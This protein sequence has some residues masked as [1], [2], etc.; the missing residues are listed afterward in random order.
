MPPNR[1]PANDPIL[2]PHRDDVG[3]LRSYLDAVL[4]PGPGMPSAVAID[5]EMLGSDRYVA[6]EIKN[7]SQERFLVEV[8]DRDLNRNA[9]MQVLRAE[10]GRSPRPRE[11][12]L[13]EAQTLAGLTHPALP[14]VFDIGFLPSGEIYYTHRPP[15]GRPAS[16]LATDESARI[17]QVE[18]LLGLATAA[19][20]IDQAGRAGLHHP[21]LSSEHVAMG[22]DGDVQ[23]WGFV[24]G[25]GPRGD[26]DAWPEVMG[27]GKV[28]YHLL[29]GLPPDEPLT[30]PRQ[31]APHRGI[32]VDLQ[33]LCLRC[34]G[35]A[36]PSFSRPQGFARAL[37][38]LLEG[39][40]RRDEAERLVL[41]A[42]KAMK[43]A[44]A[45]T[46][47]SLRLKGELGALA[48][49]PSLFHT[50]GA[51]SKR[52]SLDDALNASRAAAEASS[53]QA[54]DHL[55]RALERNP[56][57]LEALAGLSDLYFTR[58]REAE[59]ARDPRDMARWA[60]A[61][62]RVGPGR[63]D[64]R[65]LAP[66]SLTLTSPSPAATGFLSRME[67]KERRSLPGPAR[68]LG[69]LPIEEFSLAPGSYLVRVEAP[70]RA[71]VLV[72]L[73]IRRGE[74]L[75]LSIPLLDAGEVGQDWVYI[76]P[77]PCELGGD[78][79][80]PE[81]SPPLSV[82]VPPFLMARFPVTCGDFAAWIRDLAEKDPATADA[83]LPRP[84]EGGEPLWRL[85]PSGH[86][87]ATPGSS[88][89]FS[90]HP[91]TPVVG[92]TREQAR[93]YARWLS[94]R[95]GL[96]VRLPDSAEWEKAGR[97]ADARIHP[98]GNRFDSA[99]CRMARSGGGPPS[100]APVGA[101]LEDVSP[102]GVRDLAGGV[103]EWCE[104]SMP[105]A[106]HLA[107]VRGGSWASDE[108]GC[109]LTRVVDELPQRRFL[110]VG[111][112]LARDLP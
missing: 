73:C 5:G 32:P 78:P 89:A 27:L 9:W 74:S 112:R 7:R 57:S 31:R 39:E 76:P 33:V 98:W 84:S 83:C 29:A 21:H 45:H 14:S 8:L 107:P 88:S 34:F 105:G 63:H 108:A 41:Q 38:S 62:R 102:Y 91:R 71:P 111:F 50:L 17:G 104:G 94:A 52:S 80:R 72:P 6:L 22:D 90:W 58:F 46:R 12:F 26:R 40:G 25:S 28:L 30:P 82:E 24:Q 60:A 65:I 86:M 99:F 16:V 70:G 101:C 54:E 3:P 97:G 85:D 11:A 20:A 55:V 51:K 59:N 15:L 106:S 81:E 100:P 48:T 110:T 35:L 87:V 4:R 103:M 92:I 56:R 75:T 18:L 49:D 10:M 109:R 67:N 79:L 93:A 69:N 13:R 36:E 37:V 19:R 42:E 44:Q 47:T 68:T 43:Q 64:A 66:G 53:S 23:V 61:C 96:P 77:G 2:H 95:T 1:P